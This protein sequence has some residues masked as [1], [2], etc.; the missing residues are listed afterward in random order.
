M[1]IV[2]AG[3]TGLI[4][5]AL[6]RHFVA[7]G[8]EVTV[9]TR[10]R[11]GTPGLVEGAHR[12]EWDAMRLGE[13][14][15]RLDG[16]DVLINLTGESIGEGRWTDER[17]T[18]L[19]LS[20]VAPGRLLA[21]AVCGVGVPPALF[22]QASGVGYYGTGSAPR[23]ER[24]AVGDDFLATLA[25]EWEASSV[26]LPAVTRRIVARF[27]AVLSRDGGVLPRMVPPFRWFVGGRFG[28]GTQWFPWIHV[29]DVVSAI[30]HLA[31]ETDVHGPVNLVA[32]E[33]ATNR[34]VAN[35]LGRALRRP[36]WLHVPR[37][38]LAAAL[39]EQATLVLDGQQVRPRVLEE[40]GFIFNFPGVELA[41]LDLLRS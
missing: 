25:R 14:T 19:V 38:V 6:C 23:D 13:W 35:A 37:A 20:R 7:A 4:G 36:V 21:D 30:E 18:A 15:R 33:A 31:F 29:D 16:V 28:D 17:K 5:R 41:L 11:P 27:G 1:K 3:G 2:I 12:L 34:D 9:L 10:R 8:D 26:A 32:P 39:G 24:S 22:V 40:N